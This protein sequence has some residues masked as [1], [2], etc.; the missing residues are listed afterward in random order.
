MQKRLKAQLG[1]ETG[2]QWY[3]AYV[4]TRGKLVDQIF[5]EI[6]GV[7]PNLSDHGEK[8]INNVLSNACDL[9]S[10]NHKEHGLSG[11]DLCCLG[12]FILFHDV[13]NLFGRDD[14]R[15]NVSKVYD[16]ARGTDASLRRERTL[17]LSAA[18]AHTGK[19]A[20]GTYDT[21]KDLSE[22]DH[23]DGHPVRLQELAA[24]LRFAD[25]LAEGPQRTSDFMR[26]Q[27]LYDSISAIFHEYASVT[28]VFIDRGNERICLTYEIEVAPRPGENEAQADVR[29]AELLKFIYRRAVKLDQERRYARYYS[30]ILAPFKTTSIKM[31]FCFG[32]RP[33]PSTLN[34]IQLEDKM[35]PGD[36]A[37][38][39]EDLY[40][41]YEVSSLLAELKGL[42]EKA[43]QP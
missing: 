18:C 42:A 2:R 41:A 5:S 26:S 3:S 6:K 39:I 35:V 10:E 16:W 43:K 17:V 14:H 12:M 24:V 34:P 20:D 22:T 1:A 30:R 19:A 36:P 27:G 37:K 11:V 7:E 23:L 33:L 25:E 40:P 29:L 21:L 31:N 9:V 38:N 28:N 4:L 8:H 13:G 32:G 15:S